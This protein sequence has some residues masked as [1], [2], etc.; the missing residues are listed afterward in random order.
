LDA[1][2]S[3]RPA[4]SGTEDFTADEL[5]H[6]LAES[7]RKAGD[8]MTVADSLDRKL[9]GTKAQLRDGIITFTKAQIISNATALLNVREA[10][11]AEKRVLGRAGRLT[12]GGLAAAIRQAV[13]E[14]APKKAKEHREHAARQ[15][16]V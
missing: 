12:P 7:R 16:R 11:A 14:V 15:A 13:M 6:A 9:P 3:G 2:S 1:P 10:R 5:A 8:L 4:G